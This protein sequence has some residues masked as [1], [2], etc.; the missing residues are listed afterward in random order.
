MKQIFIKLIFLY[1]YIMD[2]EVQYILLVFIGLWF[3][4]CF[5]RF[6]S[7]IIF[8]KIIPVIFALCMIV[9]SVIALISFQ[10]LYWM[11]WL[12]MSWGILI[13]EDIYMHRAK[14]DDLKRLTQSEFMYR[15]KCE[16]L[17]KNIE[18]LRIC[19]NLLEKNLKIMEN[20]YKELESSAAY[21]KMKVGQL[22]FEQKIA[23]DDIK[24]LLQRLDATE[25]PG[26]K[27]QIQELEEEREH[28]RVL[29]E[30]K[31]WELKQARN[32]KQGFDIYKNCDSLDSLSKRKKLLLNIFHPDSE[33]GDNES[34]RF[35][36]EQY[37][38]RKI[39]YQ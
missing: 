11:M 7:S 23:E 16:T 30:R 19:N 27:K 18:D 25:V 14:R 39:N 9:F 34:T 29:Y 3:V 17:E 13:T 2:K 1:K 26:L 15:C 8:S 28:Y 36:L 10:W 5:L 20:D 6:T 22:K 21:W 33:G 35:I 37:N 32:A 4:C 38:M 31:E 24:D 12:I